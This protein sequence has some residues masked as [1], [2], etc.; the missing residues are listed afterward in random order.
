[1][2]IATWVVVVVAVFAYV[3]LPTAMLILI[4]DKSK[5][6]ILTAILTILYVVVLVLGVTSKVVFDAEHVVIKFEYGTD[7]CNKF[8]NWNIFSGKLGDIAI[9][10]VLLFPLGATVNVFSKG[11]LGKVALK[12]AIVGCI[13]GLLIECSQFVFPVTRSVQLSDVILNTLSAVLGGLYYYLICRINYRK[14]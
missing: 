2:T 6:K 7:W 5:V 8:I 9:N 12:C 14:Q 3:V 11:T 13:V 4:K 10:I 1:M